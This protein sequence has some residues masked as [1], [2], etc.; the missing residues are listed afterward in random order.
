[1]NTGK[2]INAMVVVLFLVLIAVGAYT[3]W[4]PFR[5][6][7]AKT[8][9]DDTTATFGAQTFTLNCR[10][11]H[12]DRGQGG[13]A[14][15][16]LALSPALDRPEF[17][18]IDNGA[19]SQATFDTNYR[20]ITNTIT[21]GRAGTFMPTWGASQGGTL[22]DEQIRQLVVLITEGHWDLAQEHADETDAMATNNA[23]VQLSS[24]S[25]SADGT[26][27]TVSNAGPFTLGQYLRI[28]GERLRVLPKQLDVQRGVDGT[29]AADHKVGATV[30]RNG[31]P[32]LGKPAPILS[33]G[34]VAL[35]DGPPATL[36]EKAAKD[37]SAFAV[38]DT[39][40]F[41]VGDTL[42][43]DDETVRV[44]GISRGIPTTGQVLAKAIGRTPKTVLVSGPQG[45][46]VGTLIRIDSEL[47]TVTGVGN[48]GTTGTALDASATATDTELSVNKP[49]FF[50]P[51]YQIRVGDEMMRVVGPVDT[52]LTLALAI[53]TAQTTLSVTGTAG[54]EQGTIIRMDDELFRVKAIVQPA[55]VEIDRGVDGTLAA[56][57]TSGVAVLKAVK[58]PAEGQPPED[59]TTG[60]T[61]AAAVTTA[62]TTV[63]VSGTTKLVAAGKYKLDDETVQ[64]KSVEPALLKVERAV[65]G[66]KKAAHSR[67]A[68]IFDGNK[69]EVKRGVDGTA[70]S[71]HNEGD[72]VYMTALKVKRQAEGSALAEHGKNT[73][74]FL[75]NQL[76]V[77]R[78]V[79][80]TQAAEHKNGTL[81][82]NFPAPPDSPTMNLGPT[83]SDRA[84]QASTT[85]SG[86][87]PTA[88]PGAT[89]VNVTLKEF[90]VTPDSSS[91]SAGAVEF[92]VTNGGAAPHN[93]RIIKTDLA[94]DKLP[95]ANSQVDETQ[96]NVVARSSGNFIA[97]GASDVVSANLTPGN[98]VLICNVPTHYQSRMHVAFTVQ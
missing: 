9:Q 26:E 96:V 46:D 74:L 45:I 87:T 77:A 15:G 97:V 25:F 65:G 58:P 13:Q 88:V 59:A 98:Y 41:A 91:V 4:D 34:A 68:S 51:D 27:L 66:T 35:V 32:V 28:D 31:S 94:P 30:L 38:G 37:A 95:V 1:M 85:P 60:Q 43:V 69:L 64:I 78:G 75:G 10:L 82:R 53:G 90:T 21:C 42:Q 22:S 2:Q 84:V 92:H 73:E 81:V 33:R 54:I 17:Q 50:R 40:G 79:L 23:T 5:S 89:I 67:R 93:F 20:L 11:C 12:G 62:D 61:L 49:T 63:D 16:R 56:A 48:D 72:T 86:P 44:T 71:A 19:F 83:C 8:T 57:H 6:D 47:M 29:E 36:A 7:A 3:I 55:R 14:G 18:G 76:V 80:G 70:A 24:G 52:D 39:S